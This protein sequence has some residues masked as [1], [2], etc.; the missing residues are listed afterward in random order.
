MCIFKYQ[1]LQPFF[2]NDRSA[3]DFLAKDSSLSLPH[4]TAS[5]I[6]NW[7]HFHNNH[8]QYTLPSKYEGWLQYR[9]VYS[10]ETTQDPVQSPENSGERLLLILVL[11]RSGSIYCKCPPETPCKKAE[12]RPVFTSF[13]AALSDPSRGGAPLWCYTRPNSVS[14]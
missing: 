13:S 4:I 1:Q 12:I 3:C 11:S 8:E 7:N 6:S 5:G 14:I 2:V 9:L 10:S